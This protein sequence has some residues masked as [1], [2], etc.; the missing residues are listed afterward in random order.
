MNKN[1]PI[2]KPPR[3]T[4][5]QRCPGFGKKLPFW[6]WLDYKVYFMQAKSGKKKKRKKKRKLV[7]I[8]YKFCILVYVIKYV[9]K[10]EKRD[11]NFQ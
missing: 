4:E 9:V 6:S 5:K 10:C 1:P 2:K 11:V 7:L 8:Y 3:I